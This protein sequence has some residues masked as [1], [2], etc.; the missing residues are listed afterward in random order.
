[1]QRIMIVDDEA[2]VL[3]D[4]VLT[5]ESLGYRVFCDSTNVA[6]A[7]NS[8]GDDRPDAAL[9]DI[10]VGG[11]PVWPLARALKQR[12]VP[13]VFVSA[14]HAHDEL[15]TEFAHCPAIDKPASS[16]D[17]TDALKQV[18]SAAA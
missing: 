18:L 5:V 16:G 4:L 10:D 17:I 1:M 12:G 11:T 9:L 6:E 8:L 13:T 3:L 15:E 7:M 14:N 2:L